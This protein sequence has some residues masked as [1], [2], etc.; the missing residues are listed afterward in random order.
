M[1]LAPSAFVADST[2][3]DALEQRAESVE[4]VHDRVL[5]HQGDSPVGVYILRRGAATL[6][7]QSAAGGEVMR[8]QAAPGSL[9]GL[10]GLI[11][12]E[13]YSLTAVAESGSEVG[14]VAFE[15]FSALLLAEP[16]M[17]FKVLEVL[18]AEV[19]TARQA[20]FDI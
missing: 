8:I 13:P 20:V 1:N 4:C 3:L 15:D 17:S 14:F 16:Q 12:N 19:R 9:L 10:P 5:F 7:M 11:G 18:A 2:L 6:T